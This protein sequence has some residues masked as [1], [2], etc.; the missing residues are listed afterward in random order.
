MVYSAVRYTNNCF[1]FQL[2]RELKSIGTPANE[3]ETPN[4]QNIQTSNV[5]EFRS[6]LKNPNS[7]AGKRPDFP[8]CLVDPRSIATEE[9]DHTEP[10][11]IQILGSKIR[12]HG[13]VDEEHFAESI[14]IL[15][16]YMFRGATVRV[17]L[18]SFE[19]NRL[20]RATAP[21]RANRHDDTRLENALTLWYALYMAS[22]ERNPESSGRRVGFEAP[23]A[24]QPC[25][26]QL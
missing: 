20:D 23:F 12:V 2:N 8:N 14:G 11:V 10:V 13:R 4:F 5:P 21:S 3:G 6:N 19:M 1:V 26:T 22:A 16:T 18:A 15:S 9:I 17:P 24:L 7:W 25:V